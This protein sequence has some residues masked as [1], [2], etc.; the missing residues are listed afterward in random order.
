[1]PFQKGNTLAINKG[2][3]A[4][5][6]ATILKA[7]GVDPE[8]YG[9]KSIMDLLDAAEET[10][11]QLMSCAD[12]KLR[13]QGIKEVQAIYEKKTGDSGSKMSS[14]TRDIV[15]FLT[16]MMVANELNCPDLLERMSDRCL[17]CREI[18]GAD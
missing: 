8:D 2:R 9:R 3:G 18:R 12:P 15:G 5:S 1:M 14:T 17:G 16:R 4:R 10:A 11:R 13:M 7:S 6:K